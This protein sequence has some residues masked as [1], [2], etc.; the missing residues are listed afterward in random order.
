MKKSIYSTPKVCKG[1]TGWY[2]YFT[3]AGKYFRYK[4]GINYIKNLKEREI[5]ANSIKAALHEKLK[6]GWN[7]NI[8]D[9]PV[10]NSSIDILAAIDFAMEKKKESLAPKS[11]SCYLTTANFFKEAIRH[12]SLTHL[13]AVDVKRVHIRLIMDNIKSKKK[14]SNKAYNKNLGYL[15]SILSEL[16]QWDIIENNPAHKI[17]TLKTEENNANVPPTDEEMILI[18]EN[19]LKKFP[20]FFILVASV[21]H[22]GIRPG[23]LLGVKLNMINKEITQFNLPPE[24]TK[25]D[26]YRIVPI[27]KHLRE[28]LKRK[29]EG[30]KDNDLYLLGTNRQHTNRGLKAGLDFVPGT[31]KLECDCATKLWRKLVKKD[32][33]IDVNLYAM[34]HFGANKK[35]LAG[36]D[37]DTLREL[38]GHTSK[39]MTMRYAKIVKEVYRREIMDKSP[40]L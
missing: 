5:E 30:I 39:M 12:L 37:L 33:G 15:K 1:K 10:Y 24:I 23:E 7:P 25:T 14:W 4:Y 34:K 28:L 16:I 26:K 9:L 3:Y 18:K 8:P 21:Y 38:Y 22:T 31:N 13:K 17:R 6:S 11:Y 19:I 40:D 36:M 2:V 29:I 32:L 20:D 27:N 35:I